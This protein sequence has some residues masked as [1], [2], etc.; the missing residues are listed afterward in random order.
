MSRPWTL[1]GLAAVRV[2]AAGDT[3]LASIADAVGR[4][5]ADVDLAL[6][7]LVGRSPQQA[8][9]RLNMGRAPASFPAASEPAPT[10]A[11]S[12]LRAFVQA[13]FR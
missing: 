3:D 13:L 8:V 2:L 10:P 11:S 1:E 5:K 6:W 7:A 4:F 9:D 12:G